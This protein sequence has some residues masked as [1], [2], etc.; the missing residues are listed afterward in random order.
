MSVETASASPQA[1]LA[2]NRPT[3]GKLNSPLFIWTA[4]AVLAGMFFVGLNYL[5]TV[6]THE[7]T[8]DAFIAA[9]VA[10]IAPRISG[11]VAA[12]HVLDNQM[13]RSNELLVE[14]D[15]GD[16]Q[17]ALAQKLSVAKSQS[18]SYNTA[19]QAYQLMRT[20]VA[21]AQAGA[22]KAQADVEVSAATAKLAAANFAR[23]QSL[24]TDKTIS[25]QEFDSAQA[26][27]NSAQASVNSA[28][29]K[30][31]E[32]TSKVAEA[33]AA[34]S[35]TEAQV[36]MA[37]AMWNEA[38]TNVAAARLNLSYTKIAAP[39]DGRVTRKQ[40]EPGDYLS[41]GQQILSI[42]PG[43]VWVVANF[44]ESQ[45]DKMKPG[46]PVTVEIDALGGREDFGIG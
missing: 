34:L 28:R 1:G 6:L 46:Q 23:S 27:D 8:D 11:Q 36:A 44:K 42:V 33:Q 40:V 13:M 21:T 37:L 45:L 22:R 39:Y 32:E 31:S 19:L 9:H 10:S 18:E 26:A 29:E 12:V 4:T 20:K 15:P 38:Q 14:I 43:E 17:I 3:R 41:A 35:A 24:L 25:P 7:S 5:F 2:A 30:V 16:Y